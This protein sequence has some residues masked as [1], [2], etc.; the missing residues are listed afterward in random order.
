[1]IIKPYGDLPRT[2]T[3]DVGEVIEARRSHVGTFVRAVVLHARRRGAAIVEVKVQWLDSD[4]DAW[5][6]REDE[7]REPAP[8]VAGTVGWVKEMRADDRPPLI[9]QINGGGPS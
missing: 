6:A 1:M 4:L 3:P 9:R 8:I 5:I 2:Y 7:G